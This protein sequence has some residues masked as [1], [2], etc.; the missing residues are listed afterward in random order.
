MR[1]SK[2]SGAY[3]C[4]GSPSGTDTSFRSQSLSRIQRLFYESR[5]KERNAI[6][7][8]C[9]ANRI[10]QCLFIWKAP[11]NDSISGINHNKLKDKKRANRDRPRNFN[12]Q[13]SVLGR[14]LVPC[15]QLHLQSNL[16]NTHPGCQYFL[17]LWCY[18]L[19]YSVSLLRHNLVFPPALFKKSKSA[20]PA[21]KTQRCPF[22]MRKT[23]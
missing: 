8:A 2:G 23:A 22:S 12:L 11:V 9:D 7:W 20:F 3:R 10:N 18:A 1:K 14:K 21:Y 5:F 13:S 16:P 15:D 19:V 17:P 4:W 6:H